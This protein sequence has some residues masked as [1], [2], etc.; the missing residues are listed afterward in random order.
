MLRSSLV[1]CALLT[2]SL[3]CQVCPAQ[4]DYNLVLN[5]G[6]EA[7]A[8]T[9]LPGTDGKKHSLADLKEK[10]I[11]VVVFTCLTCPTAS[12]YEKRIDDLTRKYSGKESKVAVVPICVNPKKEDQL[13][14]LTKRVKEKEYAFH[15]LYDESQKIA[16]EFGA[17]YT[18]EFYVLD[19]DRKLVYMGAM[20]DATKAS[21]VT[22][23]FV[24]N[25]IDATLAG[26]QPEKKIVVARGC[27]VKYARERRRPE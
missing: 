20:D 6:D 5:I 9:D 4:E 23:N 12:D 11:V 14:A 18:P 26:K 8:W 17:V 2:L 27:L 24:Q 16:K 21:E 19:Q 10:Q 1:L 13:E 7:P 22:E 15:Y 3:L 25:A